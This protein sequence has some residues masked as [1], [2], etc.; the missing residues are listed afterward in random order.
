LRRVA[1]VSKQD[2]RLQSERESIKESK[3]RKVRRVEATRIAFE[4]GERRERSDFVAVNEGRTKDGERVIVK[5]N[6]AVSSVPNELA[7]QFHA[8]PNE[9][10]MVYLH[11]LLRSPFSRETVSHRRCSRNVELGRR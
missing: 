5:M 4:R 11:V 8:C 6:E 9:S 7:S 10:T 3:A 2:N 1:C